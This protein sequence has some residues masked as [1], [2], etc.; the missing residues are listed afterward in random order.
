M[1]TPISA[2]VKNQ[3]AISNNSKFKIN[4]QTEFNLLNIQDTKTYKTLKKIPVIDITGQTSSISAIH[5][6][7]ARSSFMV[8]L[9]DSPEIWEINYQHPAPSG[10]GEWVHDYREDSGEAIVMSFPIRRLRLK[11]PLDDFFFDND[12]VKIFS[13]SCTGKI[14][15]IDLDLGRRIATMNISDDIQRHSNLNEVLGLT[16]NYLR[17]IQIRASNFRLENCPSK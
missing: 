10:F 1:Y 16:T 9:K 3:T 15:I 13:V 4:Y 8:A 2:D 6:A 14:Q 12:F 17:D 7:N 5:V 11:A